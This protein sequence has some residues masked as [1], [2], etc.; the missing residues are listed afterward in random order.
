MLSETPDPGTSEM[1]DGSPQLTLIGTVHRDPH[2]RQRLTSLL[3]Q[4]QPDLLTLEMSPFALHY[5]Q[6]RARPQRLRLER[7]LERLA[8]ETGRPLQELLG[9][10]VIRDIDH[11]LDLPYE[12]Q[13]ARAFADGSGNP[14][15][16]IDDS[17]I[18]SR[19]LKR[20]EAEL[21][22]YRNLQTLIALPAVESPPQPESYATAQNLLQGNLAPSI[23]RAF[24]NQRRG[25]EEVGPRDQAMAEQLRKLRDQD[26]SRQLVHIGGWVHLLD[27]PQGE[28]LFSRLADLSPVRR[29]LHEPARIPR[30]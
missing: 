15:V 20:V 6:T 7:I 5:R 4:L 30:N 2:G 11:L 27:D 9:L 22:S 8:D 18:S 1:T 21:I 23:R 17:N 10:Q 25:E 19:K 28:T 3:E 13:A 12:Y 16:L 14:L 26:Y 24:L 29:L